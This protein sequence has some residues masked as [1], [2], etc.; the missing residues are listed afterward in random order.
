MGSGVGSYS[1]GGAKGVRGSA[2]PLQKTIE[3]RTEP[4]AEL[5]KGGAVG[6]GEG[7]FLLRYK[8]RRG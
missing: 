1:T 6:A 2:D 7:G 3:G 5:G 4:R 8:R